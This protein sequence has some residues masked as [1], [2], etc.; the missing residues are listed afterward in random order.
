MQSIKAYQDIVNDGLARFQFPTEPNDLYE[1]IR[2]L[3][4]IG[5]KRIRPVLTLLT[6]EMFGGKLASALPSALA[7]EVFHN[8]SLMHDD[9][10][11]KAPLR[12]GRDTVHEKW[13]ANT[14]ILSG[15][16]MLIHSYTLLADNP[17]ALTP[18]LLK[19]FNKTAAEVCIGQQ[20]DMDYEKTTK[21]SIDNYID[22]I[23]LK[24]A[25]LIGTS[26]QMGA[27]VANA[28]SKQVELIYQYGVN[29]GIAFQLQDDF[30]DV[31]GDPH[32]FGKQPGGD[33]LENKK[34]YLLIKALELASADQHREIISWL[35]KSEYEPIKKIE[36]ILSIYN[37]LKIGDHIKHEIQK[38]TQQA[39]R[40]L[41]EIALETEKKEPL[42]KL[43]KELLDRTS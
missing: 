43:G 42:R 23:R 25:V 13:G 39:Y 34:T 36:T 9:I 32:K 29:L 3:L 35:Q 38:Y 21:V 28:N 4:G 8:F 41:D 5:G 19:T 15:D 26:L 16:F 7:I 1:P 14:A 20:L 17:P 37:N 2:Y 10:M 12:R 31:Y 11:D 27:M 40:A 33:I 6:A 22:M 24:T 18:T 30:L